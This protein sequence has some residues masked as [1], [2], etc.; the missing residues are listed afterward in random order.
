MPGGMLGIDD[1]YLENGYYADN[2]GIT[3]EANF[4]DWAL[5]QIWQQL[6][7]PEEATYFL[8]RSQGWK[9]LFD[10]E[11]KLI[12]PK[13]RQGN[14][15]HRNPLSGD[16][17]VESQRLASHLVGITRHPGSDRTNG[18]KRRIMR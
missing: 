7:Y 4:Q 9:Q 17:W 14:W 6:G 5:S 3:I 2:A 8:K 11:K 12:F 16:G 1:F 10:P 15:K 18:R 13:D